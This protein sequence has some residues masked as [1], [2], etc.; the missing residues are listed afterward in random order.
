VSVSE[1]EEV[2]VARWVGRKPSKKRDEVARQALAHMDR[3]HARMK[4]G[5][6]G[7]KQD[8]R[9][10]ALY[11]DGCN[12]PL[13]CYADVWKGQDVPTIFCS[14]CHKEEKGDVDVVSILSGVIATPE[15]CYSCKKPTL[16]LLGL[17]AFCTKC[18]R[19]FHG[20]ICG[21]M[22]CTADQDKGK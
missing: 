6:T 8:V 4:E 3:E 15:P 14:L 2:F 5:K 10:V 16:G 19:K 12:K 20:K 11:C 13:N 9:R 22:G 17:V 18:S 21:C 1:R 7:K